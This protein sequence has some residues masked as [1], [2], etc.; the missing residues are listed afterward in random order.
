[1]RARRLTARWLLGLALSD[2]ILGFISQAVAELA[3]ESAGLRKHIEVT[4]RAC[5]EIATAEWFLALVF[6]ARAIRKPSG[7]V[8]ALFSA[9]IG[10][11][12]WLPVQVLVAAAAV[13]PW[14]SSSRS[15]AGQ[16]GDKPSGVP[17]I[18]MLKASPNTF[19]VVAL[20]PRVRSAGARA[21]ARAASRRRGCIRRSAALPIGA[22]QRD[23]EGSGMDT[24]DLVA[25]LACAGPLAALRRGRLAGGAHH[26]LRRHRRRH[27]AL[28]STRPRLR[29][30]AT[31][32]RALPGPVIAFGVIIVV[33]C[34]G[35][36]LASPGVGVGR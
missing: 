33:A 23:R 21:R 35:G 1:M 12:R 13:S 9:P 32:S 8:D 26:R 28:A 22:D 18:D 4:T 24:R 14:P 17:I 2:L 29:V 34:A 7:R 25:L 31:L 5:I 27:R 16:R 6:V 30:G 15:R 20:F 36:R 10:R 19:P 11:R 3:L